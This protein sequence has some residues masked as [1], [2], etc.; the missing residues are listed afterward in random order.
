MRSEFQGSPQNLYSYSAPALQQWRNDWDCP[1]EGN[2][3]LCSAVSVS[4]D[5]ELPAA[6][7][8]MGTDGC[9]RGGE[10]LHSRE[11]I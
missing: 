2:Q 7:V 9:N 6:S 5:Q 11:E 1:E 10:V 4:V 8:R 3:L